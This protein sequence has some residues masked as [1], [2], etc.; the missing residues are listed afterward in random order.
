MMSRRS[1]QLQI[2]LYVDR[3]QPSC[4]IVRDAAGDFWKV[5]S[6]D[7]GWERR[8]PYTLTEDAQLE[9]V[10]GHYRYLL[11]IAE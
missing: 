1:A 6:G 5:P 9:S 10:P 3:S 4:W 11:G 8:Q 7:Q 2:S